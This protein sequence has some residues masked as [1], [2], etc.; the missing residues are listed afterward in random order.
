VGKNFESDPRAIHVHAE[1]ITPKVKL[2][3]GMY[4]N[5]RL[6]VNDIKVKSLPQG[7]IVGEGDKNYIFIKKAEGINPHNQQ[8]SATAFKMVEVTTG[9]TDQG[10]TEVNLLKP[11]ADSIPVVTSGAYYLQAD[12]TKEENEHGH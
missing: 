11:L 10:Y 12:M 2:L 6:L 4:V 3:P 9:V 5:G 8:D 1:I 7:A